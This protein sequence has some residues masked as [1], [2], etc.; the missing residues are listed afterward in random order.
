[1]RNI[2]NI[3]KFKEGEV[4]QLL[5]L[6]GNGDI[7]VSGNLLT[8][9]SFEQWDDANHLTHWIEY[10]SSANGS[11]NQDTD[12]V[13]GAYS[14]RLDK[15]KT[16]VVWV[17]Q[18]IVLTP[19]IYR[20]SFWCKT[21]TSQSYVGIKDI[22]NN[23]WWNGTDWQAT[24]KWHIY[25]NTDWEQKIFIFK[26][27]TNIT[28]LIFFSSGSLLA[29]SVWFDNAKLEKIDSSDRLI[30]V[31]NLR[32]DK[33]LESVVGQLEVQDLTLY[34]YDPD[35][36]IES[37]LNSSPQDI[38]LKLVIDSEE[39]TLFKGIT[40]PDML[41][42]EGKKLAVKCVTYLKALEDN[43]LTDYFSQAESLPWAASVDKLLEDIFPDSTDIEQPL[44][45][46]NSSRAVLSIIESSPNWSTAQNPE[47]SKEKSSIWVYDYDPSG[48]YYV[49][50][51]HK[52]TV[53]FYKI[54][55][56]MPGENKPRVT[57]LGIIGISDTP[58]PERIKLLGYKSGKLYLAY[59]KADSYSTVEMGYIDT[60][61][62]SYTSVG[63]A[64]ENAYVDNTGESIGAKVLLDTVT[65]DSTTE[66][67][68]FVTSEYNA[69]NG[70]T[71]FKLFTLENSG[72]MIINQVSSAY[73]DYSNGV[74]GSYAWGS[75][76]YGESNFYY[77]FGT[78]W[79]AGRFQFN[80]T[81]WTFLE[82]SGFGVDTNTRAFIKSS[83]LYFVGDYGYSY[84]K[85]KVS[86]S[87]VTDLGVRVT[88]DDTV[89]G[90]S[91]DSIGDISS[92]VLILNT[93]LSNY[94]GK[95]LVKVSDTVTHT[96]IEWID[97]ENI[98]IMAFPVAYGTYA[99][100]IGLL[101]YQTDE[102]EA[103]RPFVGFYSTS[104]RLP[105]FIIH[106]DN[107]NQGTRRLVELAVLYGGYLIEYDSVTS[108]KARKRIIGDSPVLS[109][110]QD[111]YARLPE[112]Q[113][114]RLIKGV[115]IKTYYGEGDYELGD[116]GSLRYRLNL[117]NPFAILGQSI[118][119]A[120]WYIDNYG[121]PNGIFRLTTPNIVSIEEMDVISFTDHLGRE[122]SGVV[123][124]TQ[125][126]YPHKYTIIVHSKT[127]ETEATEPD[128][129]PPEPSPPAWQNVNIT[130]KRL[131]P[132][133]QNTIRVTVTFD[134]IGG[135]PVEQLLVKITRIGKLHDDT[136]GIDEEDVRYI[137]VPNPGSGHKKVTFAINVRYDDKIFGAVYGLDRLG[138]NTTAETFTVSGVT[139]VYRGVLQTTLTEDG[140]VKEV[141][142]NA[143]EEVIKDGLVQR[144]VTVKSMGETIKN[145]IGI[146][147]IYNPAFDD[148]DG[149]GVPD[150]WNISTSNCSW[151]LSDDSFMGKNAVR[152]DVA[153]GD[154][155]TAHIQND[156]FLPANSASFHKYVYFAYKADTSLS[157]HFDIFVYL[158][159]AEY[160]KDKNLITTQD[161][162]LIH[163]T[164]QSSYIVKA[165]NVSPTLN[166][167]TRYVKVGLYFDIDNEANS[168]DLE[169]NVSY[170]YITQQ[171]PINALY[172]NQD[173]DINDKK[174]INL[175]D[176]TSSQDAATKNYVDTTIQNYDPT[177][178]QYDSSNRPT[179]DA[180]TAG[181]MIL[182]N[183]E[184]D[185]YY[186]QDL[187][188]CMGNKDMPAYS[189]VTIKTKQAPKDI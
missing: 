84:K 80:G 29:G 61:T 164:A 47:L 155:G 130:T 5:L 66:K 25:T 58:E 115:K 55:T 147:D 171:Y 76:D 89:L 184:D 30:D 161:I 93:Q 3:R 159:I 49:A 46:I 33:K 135:L 22:T 133:S 45:D 143:G 14:V 52:K 60:S 79:W 153:A 97:K 119:V 152:I 36:S 158:R 31:Q 81:S 48:T 185:N 179:C 19:G 168:D 107:V 92:Y 24:T 113:Y 140:K 88:D 178:K 157:A 72:A 108:I 106:K 68:I 137:Q 163:A 150:G 156:G 114:D 128:L 63:W 7:E 124:G 146:S 154:N 23:L 20:L 59:V 44:Y 32:I 120:Q 91:D 116:C 69:S 172:V 167:S 165:T 16:T 145:T 15:D 65:F 73:V 102:Y 96:E 70:K 111:D 4:P 103:V 41:Q 57:F 35:G 149:D 139:P 101:Q 112:M 94:S 183:Y 85:L 87:T 118:F 117:D 98:K 28:V 43:K 9:G 188:V 127:V 136:V 50:F 166:S 151:Q 38:C 37:Q 39:V 141:V 53:E 95:R 173:F 126:E 189:W 176:P 26:V 1:M 18:G 100:C 109:L 27:D 174:I 77:V 21:D 83:E 40:L 125:Y 160:D 182:Y 75:R 64:N 67:F 121:Q 90:W 11:V 99:Y 6:I 56:W 78:P 71:Y 42:R 12:V 13:D 82:L 34:L 122:Q 177:L 104:K 10:V 181:M 123:I 144:G 134:D 74:W 170:F 54:E 17:Y 175:A 186:Y 110:T 180:S 162:E 8:D 2:T 105:W 138:R 187:Q 62:Y 86:D 131:W 129:P 132:D 148:E 51:A 169:V 142:D